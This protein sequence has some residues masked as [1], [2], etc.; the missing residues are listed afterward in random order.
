MLCSKMMDEHSLCSFIS[1]FNLINFG[2]C[3]FDATLHRK[4]LTLSWWK[5][6]WYELKGLIAKNDFKK[7]SII[8][9]ML[10]GFNE[11]ICKIATLTKERLMIKYLWCLWFVGGDC[12]WLLTVIPSLDFHVVIL[13]KL[14]TDNKVPIVI[15]KCGLESSSLMQL[16]RLILL[17]PSIFMMSIALESLKLRKLCK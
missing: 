13:L 17:C 15:G 7:H 5:T 6:M 12:D 4:G 14:N 1:I 16:S 2:N 11:I 9:K 10:M 3:Y 8:N